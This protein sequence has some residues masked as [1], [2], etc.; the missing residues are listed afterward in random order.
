MRNLP[1]FYA[2]GLSQRSSKYCVRPYGYVAAPPE[3]FESSPGEL[4]A[5]VVFGE[6]G[7][8][9]AFQRGGWS[10]AEDGYTWTDGHDATIALG[11]PEWARVHPPGAGRT[12][13]PTGYT[14][15]A[16]GRTIGEW[17]PDRRGSHLRHAASGMPGSMGA[18]P[19]AAC[20]MEI[21]AGENDTRRLSCAFHWVKLYAARSSVPDEAYAPRQPSIVD[22]LDILV[23]EGIASV[24]AYLQNSDPACRGTGER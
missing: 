20:P 9:Q 17:R 12:V 8:A 7:N 13:C 6:D 22:G 23:A 2:S 16:A 4:V 1:G 10:D 3:G 5:S 19:D 21:I 11:R 24:S 18:D 14:G 15:R